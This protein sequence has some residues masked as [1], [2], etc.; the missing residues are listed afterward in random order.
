MTGLP[1][2]GLPVVAFAGIGRPEKFFATLRGLG[3]RLVAAE[4]FPDHHRYPDA[5]L[6]RLLRAARGQGAML[7]T[8]EK[9]AAR[10]AP[11][12]RREIMALPVRLEPDDWGAIE[13]ALA[14]IAPES[15]R[16][17]PGGAT[18]G[19]DCDTVS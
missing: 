1:L 9:D 19:G 15:P 14:R 12:W 18:F 5:V 7:V 13:A 6:R 8:T 10:L 17:G 2:A 16:S 4:P 11:A 3:A